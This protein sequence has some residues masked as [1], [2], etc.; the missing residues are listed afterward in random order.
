MKCVVCLEDVQSICSK[1]VARHTLAE[2]RERAEH[3][4]RAGFERAMPP[5][6][7]D[8][9]YMWAYELGQSM[10]ERPAKCSYGPCQLRLGHNG[11]HSTTENSV[12]EKAV[13]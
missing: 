9:P 7:P 12:G 2:V 8:H 10:A 11:M 13:R 5:Q 4:V 3:W 6:E 1:C